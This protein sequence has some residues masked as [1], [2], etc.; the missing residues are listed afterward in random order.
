MSSKKNAFR[1]LP[2]QKRSNHSSHETRR[3]SLEALEPRQMLSA[4]AFTAENL[5]EDSQF[6]AVFGNELDGDDT[7]DRCVILNI[8]ALDGTEL[9]ASDLKITDSNDKEVKILSSKTEN[10]VASFLAKFT[11]GE[12]YVFEVETENEDA[13]FNV[14]FTM[15]G[16]LEGNNEISSEDYYTLFG[17][18]NKGLGVS[19]RFIS[20]FK[21]LYGVDISENHYDAIYDLDGSGKITRT[22]F[23]TI[24]APNHDD[25]LVL[26]QEITTVPVIKNFEV[27]GTTPEEIEGQKYSYV[28][29]E[30]EELVLTGTTKAEDCKF[31]YTKEDGTV[32][33][34][35]M[36]LTKAGTVT[37]SNAAAGGNTIEL[38]YKILEDGSFSISFP[39]GSSCD[40]RITMELWSDAGHTMDSNTYSLMIDLVEPE[41]YVTDVTVKDAAQKDDV[42]YVKTTD[43]TTVVSISATDDA[44]VESLTAAMEDPAEGLYVRVFDED[45]DEISRK[46]I[47]ASSLSKGQDGKP[48]FADVEAAVTCAEGK[49]TLT[50]AVTDLAGNVFDEKSVQIDVVVDSTSP[51]LTVEGYEPNFHYKDEK[52]YDAMKVTDAALTL[53]AKVTDENPS[54]VSCTQNGK[55]VD[56]EAL[57][58]STT[59]KFTL[60]SGLNTIVFT[61]N[62]TA[63]NSITKT[64]LVYYS[65]ELT[66]TEAGETLQKDGFVQESSDS[67][68]KAL[69]L[70]DYF[71]YDDG[72]TFTAA[73]SNTDLVTGSVSSTGVLSFTYLQTP[74]EGETLTST[75]TVTAK[76]ADGTTCTLKFTLSYVNSESV[77][78]W[79]ETSVKND[80]ASESLADVAHI[81]TQNEIVFSGKLTIP[82]GSK[83]VLMKVWLNDEIRYEAI[84]LAQSTTQEGLVYEYDSAKGTFTL[85]L[86]NLT[87][88]IC[89]IRAYDASLDPALVQDVTIYVETE[90]PTVTPTITTSSLAVTANPQFS[91]SASGTPSDLDRTLGIWVQ[92]YASK[93]GLLG[94]QLYAQAKYDPAKQAFGALEYQL[95]KALE[96]GTYTFN[97]LTINAAGKTTAG[98]SLTIRID[99]DAPVISVPAYV[100]NYHYEDQENYDSMLVES[101]QLELTATVTDSSSAGL[102]CTLNGKTV[103]PASSAQDAYV[104]NYALKAGINTILFTATDAQGHSS[105]KTCKIYCNAP[106]VLTEAGKT[107][108]TNGFTQDYSTNPDDYKKIDVTKLFNYGNELELTIT[109]S[110]SSIV[111]ASVDA[112]GLMT[113]TYPT[114]P[115][116]GQTLTA[117]VTIKAEN[118]LGNS[119]SL[120]FRLTYQRSMEF[121]KNVTVENDYASQSLAR[122]EHI[123][124][125]NTIKMT[126]TLDPP[127]GADSLLMDVTYGESV[128]F[129]DVE[130]TDSASLGNLDYVYDSETGAFTLTLTNVEDGIYAFTVKLPENENPEE[131]QEIFVAVNTSI[132]GVLGTIQ[133]PA[134]TNTNPV[135]TL[136]QTGT[137]NELDSSLGAWIEVLATDEDG[138]TVTYART[139]FDYDSNEIGELAY[140]L[141]EDLPDGTYTL[142][143]R[144]IDAAGNVAQTPGSSITVTIDRI[145]PG[146]VVTEGYEPNHHYQDPSKLDSMLVNDR[147]L[148]MTLAVTESDST[149]VTCTRNGTTVTGTKNEDGTIS[150]EFTL[151]E[152]LNTIRFSAV[153]RAGNESNLT[154]LVI[155]ENAPLLTEAGQKLEANGMIQAVS[156]DPTENKTIDLNQIFEY[157]GPLTYS[158][159]SSD[160]DLATVSV[161]Q[162]GILSFNYRTKPIGDEQFSAQITVSAENANG[163]ISQMTFT[164]TCV[165]DS[166]PPK[167]LNVQV[168]NDLAQADSPVEHLLGTD[169]IQISGKLF[170]SSE[171]VSAG[172]TIRRGNEVLYSGI[173]LLEDSAAGAGYV[174]AYDEDEGSFEFTLSGVESG[175]YVFCVYGK[176][177]N[178]NESTYEGGDCQLTNVTVDL[179]EPA[180]SAFMEVVKTGTS[181][182][183][184]R[185]NP[186]F[187]V[188]ASGTPSAM[189]AQYGIELRIYVSSASSSASGTETLYAK[190]DFNTETGTF[191]ELQY[192]LEGALAD[193]NWNFRIETVNVTGKTTE[194]P[195]SSK[196]ITIDSASPVIIAYGYEEDYDSSDYGTYKKNGTNFDSMYVTEEFAPDGKYELGLSAIDGSDVAFTIS[197]FHASTGET[198]PVADENAKIPLKYGLNTVSV[199]AVDGAGNESSKT[200]TIYFNDLPLLSSY[201][202]VLNADGFTQLVGT[203]STWKTIK[204]SECFTDQESLQFEAANLDAS[205]GDVSIHVLNGILGFTYNRTP[206]EEEEA[207]SASISVTA[208]DEFGE[209]TVLLF[210]VYYSLDLYPPVWQNL[211]LEGNPKLTSS[212][213][214]SAKNSISLSGNLYDLSGIKQAELDVVF[215]ENSESS[216][217]VLDSLNLLENS[218]GTTAGGVK[219]EYV[220]VENSEG[221]GGSFTLLLSNEDGTPIAEGLYSCYVAGIDEV[222]ND[223]INDDETDEQLV[224]ILIDRTAPT[225]SAEMT[226]VQT[227]KSETAVNANPTFNLTFNQETAETYGN[228]VQIYCTEARDDGEATETL[229]AS[230]KFLNGTCELTYSKTTLAE[231]VWNFRIQTLDAAGNENRS[232]KELTITI[233]RTA[234]E[235]IYL[236]HDH[237][238]DTALEDGW[239]THE[240]L[241]HVSAGKSDADA[242]SVLYYALS[243]GENPGT[244]YE[245][246]KGIT[247]SYG[248]NTLYFRLVDGAGN[249][250]EI[251]SKTILKFTYDT[252]PVIVDG[253]EALP[254]VTIR[255]PEEEAPS[256]QITLTKAQVESLVTDADLPLGDS[257]T[258]DF[259]FTLPDGTAE[260]VTSMTWVKDAE[261]GNYV[262]TLTFSDYQAARAMSTLGTISLIVKD[263]WGVSPADETGILSFS[264]SKNV[265]PVEL[266]SSQITIPQNETGNCEFNMNSVFADP[267]GNA[268]KLTSYEI[269]VNGVKAENVTLSADGQSILWTPA[270]GKYGFVTINASAANV[271]ANG[272]VISSTDTGTKTISGTVAWSGYSLTGMANAKLALTEGSGTF[273][274]NIS[275]YLTVS[276][277]FDST[278]AWGGYEVSV[279][280]VSCTV[281]SSNSQV[282]GWSLNADG[283]RN[284]HYSSLF[285][286]APAVASDRLS[287]TLNQYAYGSASLNFRISWNQDGMAQ[288]SSTASIPLTVANVVAT[289]FTTKKEADFPLDEN[290]VSVA[291]LQGCSGG[292]DDGSVQFAGLS[293]SSIS[294]GFECGFSE[295]GQYFIIRDSQ[296]YD[297]YFTLTETAVTETTDEAVTHSGIIVFTKA[298]IS[299]SA[300]KTV[301]D[302]TYWNR[303]DGVH[304][305]LGYQ[306]Q[307]LAT[308]ATGSNSCEF[309]F[310]GTAWDLEAAGIRSAAAQTL[311]A[312]VLAAEQLDPQ[313]WEVTAMVSPDSSVSWNEGTFQ[314]AAGW[315]GTAAFACTLKNSTTGAEEKCSVTL[316]IPNANLAPNWSEG[317]KTTDGTYVW[318]VTQNAAGVYALDL[319]QIISDFD[320]SALTFQIQEAPT[321]G[322]AVL[323]GSVLT[324]TANDPEFVTTGLPFSVRATSS[325]LDGADSA[326]ADFSLKL[327]ISQGSSAPVITSVSLASGSSDLELS[328]VSGTAA[329]TLAATVRAVDENYEFQISV[330]DENDQIVEMITLNATSNGT[331][332]PTLAITG[333]GVAQAGSEWI[334]SVNELS[335]S[336]LTFSVSNEIGTDSESIQVKTAGT[337]LISDESLDPYLYEEVTGTLTK[338]ATLAET[339]SVEAQVAAGSTLKVGSVLKT[340][341]TFS[342]SAFSAIRSELRQNVDYRLLNENDS[343][344]CE[345]LRDVTASADLTT[346]AYCSSVAASTL[347]KGSSLAVGSVLS[348][349]V[350]SQTPD[351]S[352][353]IEIYENYASDGT[354]LQTT[355]PADSFGSLNVTGIQ[356]PE[357]PDSHAIQSIVRNANGSLT[358]TYAPYQLDQDRSEII[359]QLQLGSGETIDFQVGLNFERP[360]E[361][362][363][364][365]TDAQNSSA[366]LKTLPDSVEAISS[367]TAAYYVNV[368]LECSTPTY[369]KEFISAYETYVLGTLVELHVNSEAVSEIEL[370]TGVGDGE[371]TEK[372]GERICQ[373]A[374]VTAKEVGSDLLG[375]GTYACL[376]QFKITT[377][378]TASLEYRVVSKA[379]QGGYPFEYDDASETGV[380]VMFG[381]VNANQIHDQTANTIPLEMPLAAAGI[382]PESA[383]AREASGTE[384]LMADA[385]V[386]ELFVVAGTLRE[387]GLPVEAPESE[388]LANASD[389]QVESYFG[390]AAGSL[391]CSTEL[392]ASIQDE[393]S[394]LKALEASPAIQAA[395][396]ALTDAAI[397]AGLE[398]KNDSQSDSR[399]VKRR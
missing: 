222:G 91:T 262:L 15:A 185:S 124:S 30:S 307:N 52:N 273:S 374:L 50:I 150:F 338:K 252:V 197:V 228:W 109:S 321:A 17:E 215:N 209:K 38:T 20:V 85:T 2:D 379:I 42:F 362:R 250:S 160:T 298:F 261:T 121:L 34:G 372:D 113:L 349:S 184:V 331:Q 334:L 339:T 230:G 142:S 330:Q 238:N 221:T 68:K 131:S 363:T 369:S 237:T 279:T 130:L 287:F 98:N 178:G 271:D 323:N 88:G 1:F 358:V 29:T 397:Q 86:S 355:I 152:D 320:H 41:A 141:S 207:V 396:R 156:S 301:T 28:T 97:C 205:K 249:V 103:E 25:P 53:T 324:F 44:T 75:I 254:D 322:R 382:L 353:V 346:D 295:D 191:G 96:D 264:V 110:D 166:L 69:N 311:T 60:A 218:S 56:P 102:T 296:N 392:A 294:A 354:L 326:S 27:N 8:A 163:K 77:E 204:L 161:S 128:I 39:D 33:S 267:Q 65:A 125:Q 117:D 40:G 225:L 172:M 284:E 79:T 154:C 303:L 122:F 312:D 240:A 226:L 315:H 55:A 202:E 99:A 183:V 233:D 119:V 135:I 360:F 304:L 340:G 196:T 93:Q 21:N 341:S 278:Q 90:A 59:F 194:A 181:E 212:V 78:Y 286:S 316:T 332:S 260:G 146:L 399:G 211:E 47:T 158:A 22:V 16:D 280:D 180:V 23:D 328:G 170:D 368:W 251:S 384:T 285:A 231:G 175:N 203:P 347:A 256:V 248:P 104:F 151:S 373:A 190:A 19:N 395:A 313:T 92:I 89:Q 258:Y 108:Q 318:S 352:E 101:P 5:V 123:I 155:W 272:N 391:G 266:I 344:Y 67:D 381:Y 173:N 95:E 210:T 297:F 133:S 14:L 58:G 200:F 337:F 140:L 148:V 361:L 177:V 245:N 107:L 37:L 46:Q 244:V 308:S 390:N 144:T 49:H 325:A 105:T 70:Y 263:S 302:G 81:V 165:C 31:T 389:V 292:S 242:D 219:Y 167:W 283:S 66:L 48:V 62:D 179:E 147:E 111:T 193:G 13:Q 342:W 116:E 274:A 282:S 306:V 371:V 234:P 12:T 120:T 51:T 268:W 232:E 126:G 259:S 247:L 115:E 168:K 310:A 329:F 83:G 188:T 187:T 386:S 235:I 257:L 220:Y 327:V 45:G 57:A 394:L 348:G 290:Q 43:F 76:T 376:G 3:S 186:K 71:S 199:K 74:E 94:S 7:S 189:D 359:I 82:E 265:L 343:L 336:E 132:P 134:F 375:A 63:G 195:D 73:S 171:I 276:N 206:G 174:Y 317:V 388:T 378:G 35:Q 118:H 335:L 213:L 87:S 366:E 269:L 6:Q 333:D 36:D 345:L 383:A 145:A 72:L 217:L 138:K 198:E 241:L 305:V 300:G 255:F 143:V 100:E 377:T 398:T 153:D 201:G 169:S 239:L 129:R 24:I 365:V 289:P 137:L 18:V 32:Y 236:S 26:T 253:A 299:D 350:L 275:D 319:S 64:C 9:E 192:L 227:G 281:T 61:A 380:G 309:T 159:S 11:L 246:S 224:E 106:V 176:D 270:N 293:V 112:N 208:T 114:T 229:Y 216:K 385:A 214:A 314:I 357:I 351:I 139:T 84:N 127:D 277:A 10:G 4:V 243:Q 162:E 393:E 54:G 291:L 157:S 356:V 223:S 387:N 136:T 288:S 364:T 80:Y 149:T 367:E 370:V 182:S 164:L